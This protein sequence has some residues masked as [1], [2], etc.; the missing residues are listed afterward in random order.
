MTRTRTTAGRPARK[1]PDKVTRLTP[2]PG[3]SGVDRMLDAKLWNN[4]CWFAFRLNY[5]AL[6]YNTPLYDWIKR[7]YGLSRVEYVVIYSLAL[8][9]GGQARDISDSSGFP[10]PTLSRAVARLTE[11]GLIVQTKVKGLGRNQP[12]NLSAKGW[13][14]FRETLPAFEAHERTMLAALSDEEQSTLAHLLARVVRS[15]D[16][17]PDFIPDLPATAP[18]PVS[19]APIRSAKRP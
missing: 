8:S 13:A 12:L 4:P 14:L 10:K 15:A 1:T 9:D 11:L 6:R 17:W 7:A 19:A 3:V 2:E 5:L 18:P 16:T